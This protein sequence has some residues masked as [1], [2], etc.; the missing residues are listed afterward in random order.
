MSNE[1][2]WAIG[3][4]TGVVASVL[5]TVAVMLG[6]YG[7]SARTFLGIPRFAMISIHRTASL[8]SVV[9]TLV[10]VLTVTLDQYTNLTFINAFIPFTSSNEPLWYGLGAIAL[11]L[12]LAISVTGML[13]SYI[14]EKTFHA[15][16]WLAYA[17][18]P[19]AIIHG[20]GA[21]TDSISAWYLLLTAACLL[22]VGAMAA[23]RVL[24]RFSDYSYAR[25][26][27]RVL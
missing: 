9:F 3:R 7:R 23:W 16:H 25:T 17:S 21:G 5:L 2:L 27:E 14:G 8:F 12:L 19:I 18:W 26:K 13:R 11:D 6:I 15:V 4:G 10:H 22:A 1:I 20:L 24:P